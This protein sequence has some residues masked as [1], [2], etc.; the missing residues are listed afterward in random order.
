MQDEEGNFISKQRSNEMRGF[1][2][3][4]WNTFGEKGWL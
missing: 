1:A 4:L 2:R 3:K